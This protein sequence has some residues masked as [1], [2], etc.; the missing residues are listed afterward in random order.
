MLIPR[1]G[2]V[3]LITPDNAP[4]LLHSGEEWQG[5]D[6]PHVLVD[7]NSLRLM[8]SLSKGISIDPEFGMTLQGP[9]SFPESLENIHFSS[10][11]AMNP[12]LMASIGSSSCMPVPMLVPSK[13]QVLEGS[14]DMLGIL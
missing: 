12:L 4:R 7:D 5:P 3:D 9:I 14:G 6:Y 13:P 1:D 11:W 8:G 2:P 10:Y